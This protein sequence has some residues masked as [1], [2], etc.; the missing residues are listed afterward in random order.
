MNSNYKFLSILTGLLT[1]VASRGGAQSQPGFVQSETVK[2]AGITTDSLLYT[3]S[4]YQKQT[5]RT[6]YDGLDR[7]IQSIAIQA[8]PAGNDLV[9][10]TAYDNLGRP[11]AGYLPYAGKSTDVMGSYRPN[12]VTTDQPAF[13]NQ[14]GQYLIAT[15]T[16][17]HTNNVYE[18]TPLQRLLKSGMV[19]SGYQPE[20]GGT[21][22]YKTISYRY[23]TSGDGNIPIWNPDG[24]FTTGHFFG[25]GTLQVMVGTDEDN[26]ANM[27]FTD[28]SGHLILKRQV[29]GATN[30]DTYYIYNTAG[31]ISYIVPP[32]AVNLMAGTYSLTATGVP[33]LIFHYVYDTMGRITQRTVPA[34][35]VEYIVY[36]PMNR[37]VLSQDSNM[38]ASNY[39]IYI[40]YDTKNRVIN[41]GE[42]ID[43]T[44]T[45][46]NS[47]QNYVNSLVTSYDTT[48][49]ERRTT[50]GAYDF[51]TNYVFPTTNI[52]PL[53]Y[54]HYDDYDIDNNG[55]ANY[56]YGRQGLANEDSVATKPVK[57]SVTISL[58]KTVGNGIMNSPWFTKVVFYDK[59]G[60]PIQVQSNNHI[61]YQDVLTMTDTATTVPDFTG[62]PQITL[63]K[64]K[65]S[66][67]V[68]TK[69]QTNLTY[70]QMYRVKAVDQY[71]NGSS[72]VT[73]VAAYNYNELGQVIKKN[74]GYVS[75]SSWLQNI[76][77]RYN[78]RG[79]LLSINNSK[80]SNDGGVTNGD[81]N[82]LFGMQLLYDL[83]DSNLGNT[84]YY[85]GKVSAVKWMS[86]DG[87]NNSSYERAFR[88]YYDGIGRDTA[89]IYAERTTAGTGTFTITHG[90]DEN[91]ITYDYNGNIKTLYRNSA[92]QG[93]GN[94][95]A[96]DN[97]TYAYSTTNP[98][99]LTSVSDASGSSLGFA[100]GTGNYAYDGNG[101]AK[102]DPYKGIA[103]I[104]YDILNKTD[105]I[106]F[107]SSANRYLTYTYTA[108]GTLLRKQ[109]WDNVSG[110]A[111][112]ISTTDYLDGFVYNAAGTGSD[113]LTYFPTVEGRVLK[114]GATFSIEYSITDWQG[115]S[116]ITFDNKGTGGTAKVEQENSYYA[117]GLIMPGSTV[118]TPTLP[119]KNL[120]NGGSEWQNDYSNLP[121]YYQTFYRNYDAAL[122]RWIGVDPEP[123]SAESITTYQYAGNNPIMFNDPLGNKLLDPSRMPHPDTDPNTGNDG[124]SEGG[125][126]SGGDGL[127]DDIENDW[128]AFITVDPDQQQYQS[129][130]NGDLGPAAK[131]V[132]EAARE[133]AGLV[134]GK[135]NPNYATNVY[136]AAYNTYLSGGKVNSS[137][138]ES[139]MVS[140][141][142]NPSDGS[143]GVEEHS[144]RIYLPDDGE[145]ANQGL[146]GY[147]DPRS[148]NLGTVGE[149]YVTK[150]T[151]SNTNYTYLDIWPLTLNH[152]DVILPPL[153]VQVRNIGN[154]TLAQDGLAKAW[155]LSRD[156]IRRENDE[157]LI[158][159][160]Y[161]ATKMFISKFQEYLKDLF[162][163]KPVA[164][165]SPFRGTTPESEVQYIEF[166]AYK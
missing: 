15:D 150:I 144:F 88:Y 48:W 2:V 143:L 50:S 42:Y 86:K 160:D 62:V 159:D 4:T 166:K 100:G 64:K 118:A 35:G 147:A 83:A 47:M 69:V 111:T 84:P 46:L 102:N 82:D 124:Q 17:A 63:V 119:N 90:W 74:L 75:S 155:D 80:L 153:Y 32:Q 107:T 78:I 20:G 16:A 22:H 54:I 77:M 19:G 129:A 120:Y 135:T 61:Y 44:H 14:T 163:G 113:T 93:A 94:H 59:R 139:R 3:L 24:T 103:S 164:T 110:T 37:P 165:P 125:G 55:S 99:Q 137:G 104:Y 27:T 140:Y 38:R 65:T 96:I 89:A 13:Y 68:T 58:N 156:F 72:T 106:T 81:T 33:K 115:N 128:N 136:K 25:I 131:A 21:Q 85:N 34:K 56:V 162:G 26:M 30:L 109:Q 60:N 23:N 122:G 36:D 39:W 108:D 66:A 5:T 161:D 134:A 141:Q 92:T 132:A 7:P 76:D 79:Q 151:N 154:E 52:A 43:A 8:S 101:N 6:Y 11:V 70:D 40:K 117:F 98:N 116:R 87:S 127:P 41:K 31:M 29:M 123:E 18:N 157:G 71:Y 9:Q 152:V 67:T 133:K 138:Y 142:T 53:S 114:L 10:A 49:S 146:L 145:T 126:Y 91:R 73:H 148:F 12:A 121:D 95:T 130:L 112:L 28:K 97:L 105:K 57:G 51:Y 45:S 158:E 1:F 149:A